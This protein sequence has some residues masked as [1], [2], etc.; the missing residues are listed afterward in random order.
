MKTSPQTDL[1]DAAMAKARLLVPPLVKDAVNPRFGSGYTTLYAYDPAVRCLAEQGVSVAQ[2]V[3]FLELAGSVGIGVS[4]RFG[5][6]GQ[7]I[8][9]D[10][11]FIPVPKPDAHSIA[12][13][14][15]Y[16]RKISLGAL[17]CVMAHEEDDDGN[18]LTPPKRATREEKRS[19]PREAPKASGV[20]VD[21]SGNEIPL[22]D[23]DEG[24]D[25]GAPS[26]L[27]QVIETILNLTRA[28]NLG[29]GAKDAMWETHVGR[30]Y[31]PHDLRKVPLDK[32]RPLAE[33]LALQERR[34][35]QAKP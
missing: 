32:L 20:L 22:V 28:L 15:T 3:A 5:K 14:V 16:G 12:A 21:D 25:D 8:E 29:Q 13:A 23:L 33:S 9:S 31:S 34:A 18:S 27:D 1:I 11:T 30:G 35:T 26:E 7:W 4:T 19:V 6:D 17:G 10:P 2:N 24:D